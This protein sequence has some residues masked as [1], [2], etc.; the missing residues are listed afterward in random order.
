MQVALIIPL[1]EMG[2][3][4]HP[5]NALPGVPGYPAHPLPGQ[6]GHPDQ[7]LPGSQP[8]PSHPIALPPGQGWPPMVNPPI[9]PPDPPPNTIWPP[10]PPGTGTKKALV[11]IYISGYGERHV[12]IDV[13]EPKY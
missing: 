7:G 3:G 6:P 2:G 8:R 13:P 9:V 11:L 10:L 4:L 12:V 1:G 5:G